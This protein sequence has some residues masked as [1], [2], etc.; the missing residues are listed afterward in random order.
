MRQPL[1]KMLVV[2]AYSVCVRGI[3]CTKMENAMEALE[4]AF[5]ERAAGGKGVADG[6]LSTGFETAA[7]GNA[8]DILLGF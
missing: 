7:D 5:A 4:S 3:L 6:G 1:T 8:S 2:L